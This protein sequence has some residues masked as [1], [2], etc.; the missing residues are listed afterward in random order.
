MMKKL[1]LAIATMVATMGFAFAQVDVNKADVAA[2]DSVKGVGPKMSKAI[3]DERA[4]GE[5][6]DWA[7][8]EKRVKGVGEKS[9][10]KLS[11]AGLQVNGKSRDGAPATAKPADAKAGKAAA[12]AATAAKPAVPAATAGKP[13][14][15]AKPAE[16]KKPATT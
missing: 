15:A 9:S 12:P 5:F 1:M 3:L 10:A 4:K 11:A 16:A 2:L 13:T 14:A 8:F 6:K 7:D